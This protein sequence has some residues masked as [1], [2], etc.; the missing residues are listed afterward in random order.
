MINNY[1][2]TLFICGRGQIAIHF[3]LSLKKYDKRPVFSTCC[4]I[5]NFMKLKKQNRM[6]VKTPGSVRR[7]KAIDYLSSIRDNVWMLLVTV[8]FHSAPATLPLGK[9]IKIQTNRLAKNSKPE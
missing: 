5:W 7:E 9:E 8:S 4:L 2:E 3:P 6:N 1:T